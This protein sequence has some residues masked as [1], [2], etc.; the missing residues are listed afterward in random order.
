[1]AQKIHY[2]YYHVWLLWYILNWIINHFFPTDCG[3][4]L[5]VSSRQ[6]VEDSTTTGATEGSGEEMQPTVETFSWL[7]FQ[8]GQGNGLGGDEDHDAECDV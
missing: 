2:R 5:P 7:R 6:Y 3:G 4:S 1:M 8:S